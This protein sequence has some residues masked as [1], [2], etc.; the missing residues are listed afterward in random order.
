MNAREFAKGFAPSIG[1]GV[2]KNDNG[3]FYGYTTLEY[4]GYTTDP[5]KEKDLAESELL[6]FF[7]GIESQ[8]KSIIK[9]LKEK[10]EE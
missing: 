10:L 3:K 1:W 2:E 7:E 8:I 4:M 9:T 5:Y 6:G